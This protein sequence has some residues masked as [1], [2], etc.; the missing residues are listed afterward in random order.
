M[1]DVNVIGEDG[2]EYPQTNID[3]RCKYHRPKRPKNIEAEMLEEDVLIRSY[4]RSLI[5]GDVIQMQYLTGDIFAGVL[6]ENR[7]SE[8]M[9]LVE[10]LP[11]GY[12]IWIIFTVYDD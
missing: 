1:V 11:R 9:V 12:V 6:V 8:E 5:K 2:K 10:L 3:Y 7:P 4:S